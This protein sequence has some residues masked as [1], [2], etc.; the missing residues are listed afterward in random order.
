[1][2]RV[3]QVNKCHLPGSMLDASYF[4][5]ILTSSKKYKSLHIYSRETARWYKASMGSLGPNWSQIDHGSWTY[6]D[7]YLDHHFQGISFV[8]IILITAFKKNNSWSL[9]WSPLP[10]NF[11]RDHYLDHHFLAFPFLIIVLITTFSE[12]HEL[13]SLGRL[14]TKSTE[15]KVQ[16]WSL[17][18]WWTQCTLLQLR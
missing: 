10:R 17:K 2:A 11:H 9:S 15:I 5:C 6:D 18:S 14:L 3:P 12:F 7:H 8:I 13:Q 1:M 4:F 16:G